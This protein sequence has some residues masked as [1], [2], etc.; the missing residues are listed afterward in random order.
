MF[1]KIKFASL[2]QFKEIK[3]LLKYIFY[4]I[5]NKFFCSIGKCVLFERGFR[6]RISTDSFQNE[7]WV[8]SYNY[9]ITRR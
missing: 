9:P 4:Q 6:P 8:D 7:K 3:S 2:E 1:N 5:A